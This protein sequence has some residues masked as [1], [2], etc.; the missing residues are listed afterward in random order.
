MFGGDMANLHARRALRPP[1]WKGKSKEG[2][3]A[4]Q[5]TKRSE[6]GDESKGNAAMPRRYI[7]EC[8]LHHKDPRA[9]LPTLKGLKLKPFRCP[10]CLKEVTPEL[11]AEEAAEK[12]RS[13]RHNN[14]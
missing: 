7:L 14:G 2:V 5:L 1:V 4:R 10:C 3:Y 9:I 11:E 8:V 13:A 12:P 6:R